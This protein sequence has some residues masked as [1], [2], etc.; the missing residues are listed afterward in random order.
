MKALRIIMA[1]ILANYC[2]T[3]LSQNQ[4]GFV[5]TLGRPNQKGQALSGV[6][7]RAKGAHNA[8]LSKTDGTFVMPMNGKK[9]GDSYSLQQ[10]QKTGYELNDINM[11]GRPYAF[12]ASIPLTIVMVSSHQLQID[13]QRIEDRAFIVAE[14]NYKNKQALLEQQKNKNEISILQYREQLRD[15]Q[16]KFDKYQSMIEGMAE[17]YARTDYDNLDEKECEINLCIEN[18]EL[19]QAESLLREIGFMQRIANINNLMASGQQLMENANKD[20][21]VILKQQEKDAEH[22]YQLDTISLGRFDN[23]KAQFYI[24][25]RAALDSTNVRWQVDAGEFVIDYLNDIDKSMQYF[26]RAKRHSNKES[27]EMAECYNDIGYVYIEQGEFDKAQQ[28]LHQSLDL[29]EKLVSNDH[30]KVGLAY[31]SLGTCFFVQNKY[32]DALTYHLQSLAIRKIVYGENSREVALN[33]HNIGTTLSKKKRYDEALSCLHTALNT[34]NSIKNRGEKERELLGNLYDAISSTYLEKADYEKNLISKQALDYCKKALNS[35][36]QMYGANN[37]NTAI[38]YHNLGAYYIGRLSYF[39]N[40]SDTV[41]NID[42]SDGEKGLSFL[43]KSLEIK[44]NV[45]EDSHYRVNETTDIIA[46]IFELYTNL[47]ERNVV[48]DEQVMKSQ[49]GRT[50][51]AIFYMDKAIETYKFIN[52]SSALNYYAYI[53]NLYVIGQLCGLIGKYDKAYDY[54]IELLPIM[55]SLSKKSPSWKNKYVTTLGNL[56]YF[57]IFKKKYEEAVKYAKN[58]ISIDE[59]QTY[60]YTNLASALLFQGKYNQA[61]SIYIKYKDEFKTGFIEDLEVFEQNNIIPVKYKNEVKEIIK[62]LNE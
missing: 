29:R 59:T 41:L 5:K 56:S 58:G 48:E 25:T 38:S 35:R 49:K 17:H 60:L 7:V 15:L 50:E 46:P 1:I 11:I 18:G 36:L 33:Y 55:E 57:S 14:K 31:N 45:V 43:L 6:S 51:K 42:I 26:L 20:L 23:I 28:I 24:E 22:L 13:K 8:V 37:L 39:V 19:E 40:K 52:Q 16:D 9:E 32:D 44:K 47:G 27:M 34:L 2:F 12:S 61:K 30:P 10:V 21:E 53:N 62:L 54:Y 3:L 4:Q